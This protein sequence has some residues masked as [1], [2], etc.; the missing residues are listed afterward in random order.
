MFYAP[1]ETNPTAWSANLPSSPVFGGGQDLPGGG[2]MPWTLFFVPIPGGPTEPSPRSTR[3]RRP[4]FSVS[5]RLR[6]RP[7]MRPRKAL[8]LLLVIA[9]YG[10]GYGHTRPVIESGK[11]FPCRSAIGIEG[12]P[13]PSEVIAMIGEPLE[14][15]PIPGGETFRYAVRGKYGDR[16]KLFGLVTISEPHY[17]WSCDVRL[18][19]RGG[20]LYSI[21]HSMESR[22][23]DGAEKD[24]PTTRILKPGK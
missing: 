20:H 22:G 15:Q 11:D 14:R 13:T 1:G 12:E 19:F 21:T 7:S 17:F 18:E 3:A 4:G 16:V 6:F 10:C 9:A 5:A 23:P 8:S 24:G 2:L